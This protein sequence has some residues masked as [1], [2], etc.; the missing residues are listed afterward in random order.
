MILSLDIGNTHPNYCL[1]DNELKLIE[2][3]LVSNLDQTINYQAV[4]IASV[5]DK[6]IPHNLSASKIILVKNYLHQK[7][8]LNMPVHYSSTL[9]VD[10]VVQGWEL[11]NQKKYGLLIDAGSFITMDII[12]EQG[13][14]GG[15]ILP[16]INKLLK[17]YT[18]GE[19]LLELTKNELMQ[20]H[21][22]AAPQDTHHAILGGVKLMLQAALNQ[23]QKLY[24]LTEEQIYVTGGDADLF[25]KWQPGSIKIPNLMHQSLINFYG[26]V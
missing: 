22:N 2:S 17:N 13:F 16:G 18:T 15:Y 19:Q 11:F 9:G 25:Q 24:Q 7:Y 6:K 12:S 23:V 4:I 21:S 3:G 14:M 5:A 8:F 26:A 1:W 20:E 10:R